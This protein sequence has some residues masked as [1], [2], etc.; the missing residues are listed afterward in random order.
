MKPRGDQAKG[1]VSGIG[2][3]PKGFGERPPSHKTTRELGIQGLGCVVRRY[4]ERP[5]DVAPFY[6]DALGIDSFRR[7]YPAGRVQSPTQTQM[8]WAGDLVMLEINALTV[9]ADTEAR[10]RDVALLV[11]VLEPADSMRGIERSGGT[12]VAAGRDRLAATMMADPWGRL[13]GLRPA[14]LPAKDAERTGAALEGTRPAEI[15][16]DEP[17]AAG[18]RSRRPSGTGRSW[19]RTFRSDLPS[20]VRCTRR[21]FRDRQ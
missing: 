17:G 4:V 20:T 3:R 6:K 2:T 14:V 21:S 7:F 15:P 13:I 19:V 8:L 12:A 1:G 16:D 5:A 10:L 11:R 18:L 9:S